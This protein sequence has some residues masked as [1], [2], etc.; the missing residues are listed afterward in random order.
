MVDDG[1]IFQINTKYE[2]LAPIMNEKIRRYWA[3]SEAMSLGWGGVSAVSQA[4]GLSRTT[5]QTG[6]RELQEPTPSAM[7]VDQKMRLRVSGAGRKPLTKTDRGLRRALEKLLNSSTSGS[8]V[9]SLRWT[10]TSCRHLADEL[11]RQGHPVSER[12]VN[13]LLHDLDY[14]LQAN[15]KTKEG[16]DHPDR[17]AQFKH[18]DSQVRA[19]Q[20]R[21]WPVISVDAKKRELMGDFS[22]AGCEWR[23]KGEPVNVR[24]YDFE[25]KKLGHAIPY[26]VYDQTY[27]QGWVSV[28]IDHD[29]AEFST[30]TIRRGWLEMGR[31]LYPGIAELLITADGGG[32]NSSRSRLWKVCLQAL[33]DDLGLRIT[34][35]HFPPGTSKWNKIEHRMF[36]HIS[37]NWRGKPLLSRLV[38]VNLIGKTTTRSGLKIEAG[39]DKNSYPTGIRVTDEELANVSL[40]KHKF[41]GEWNYTISPQC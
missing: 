38:I 11:S 32:S 12:T 14:S 5:I 18:I 3:A 13:R 28:G 17:D 10:S 35:C 8:P 7:A 20:R 22:Q 34:V 6:I 36:C 16:G 19:F 29:T 1:T 4:S 39:L 30:E 40:K 41:H 25:D 23:P 26:G 37:Q 31:K 33:A 27:N 21:G 15:Y 24:V 2:A 9:S